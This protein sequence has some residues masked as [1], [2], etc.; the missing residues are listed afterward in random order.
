MWPLKLQYTRINVIVISIFFRFT[1]RVQAMTRTAPMYTV[2]WSSQIV[3]SNNRLGPPTPAPNAV[4]AAHTH[5]HYN[6]IADTCTP[7][8]SYISSIKLCIIFIVIWLI[9]V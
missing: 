3:R 1:Y 6:L 7:L 9:K 4:S 8:A 5:I 2:R